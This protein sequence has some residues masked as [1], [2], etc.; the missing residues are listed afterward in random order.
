VSAVLTAPTLADTVAYIRLS[1]GVAAPVDMWLAASILLATTVATSQP[2]PCVCA[3]SMGCQRRRN[4]KHCMCWGRTDVDHLGHD[5]CAARA[6][7]TQT[8]ALRALPP[9]GQPR[10]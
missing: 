2:Y 10:P 6:R 1:T 3:S 8:G 4:P 9:I 5:C 7:H